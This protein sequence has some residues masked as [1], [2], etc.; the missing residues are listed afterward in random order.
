MVV[1]TGRSDGR[2]PDELTCKVLRRFGVGKD[3]LT[4]DAV[5]IETPC[6]VDFRKMTRKEATKRFCGGCKKHVHDLASMTEGEARALLT[7]A[8]TE[9]LCIRYV[10]D[11]S[12]QLLFLPDVPVENLTAR[13]RATMAASVMAAAVSLAGCSAAVEESVAT[14]GYSAQAP[15]IT[16]PPFTP[17]VVMMGYLPPPPPIASPNST[18][19]SFGANRGMAMLMITDLP[20][21]L[22][23]RTAPSEQATTAHPFLNGMCMGEPAG[24]AEARALLAES[25][26]TDEFLAKLAGAGFSVMPL[27]PGLLPPPGPSL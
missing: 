8:P 3:V 18:P 1:T 6:G 14:V 27:F 9:G 4:R 17:P 15:P 7:S 22:V 12:G 13:K 16:Q 20:G 21:N 19:R 10:A 2:R 11:G 5:T 24:C 26:N 23:D 25:R